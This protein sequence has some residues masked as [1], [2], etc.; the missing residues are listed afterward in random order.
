MLPPPKWGQARS[1]GLQLA[2]LLLPHL[3]FPMLA[4][5]QLQPGAL[6]F[7]TFLHF[8]VVHFGI[9]EFSQCPL[10]DI[11]LIVNV[12]VK[13]E[14]HLCKTFLPTRVRKS[15]KKKVCTLQPNQERDRSWDVENPR[16]GGAWW[17]AIYGVTQSRTR[18]K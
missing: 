15:C 11:N 12:D 13:I 6:D 4:W 2:S 17:A 3:V 5:I 18:L 9:L 10:N 14:S 16:D 1:W 7:M 8:F